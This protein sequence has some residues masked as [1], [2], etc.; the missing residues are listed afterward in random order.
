MASTSVENSFKM[1]HLTI[2]LAIIRDLNSGMS[3]QQASAKYTLH[4][5]VLRKVSMQKSK[6]KGP[7]T[8]SQHRRNLTIADKLRMLHYIEKGLPTNEI[9]RKFNT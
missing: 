9:A 7:Q 4:E 1:L 6:I 5:D 8:F 3:V 2:K